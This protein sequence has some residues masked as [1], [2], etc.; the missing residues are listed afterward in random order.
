MPSDAALLPCLTT[1]APAA[2]ATIDD[3][4]E[5]LTVPKRSPPVPDDVERHRVDGERQRVRE[6]GVPESDDLVDRLALRP[7]RDQEPGELGR[8]SPARP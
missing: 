3:M 6:H 5:T 8:A 2:A 7:Q 4:V 1:C